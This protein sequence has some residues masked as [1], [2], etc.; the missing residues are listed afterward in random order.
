MK[1]MCFLLP[2]CF[3]FYIFCKVEQVMAILKNKYKSFM[4]VCVSVNLYIIVAPKVMLLYY[5]GPQH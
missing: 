1:G 3:M 5:V 4:C 2:L